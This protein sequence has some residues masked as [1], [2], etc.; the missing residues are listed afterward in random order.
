M[1][2]HPK[3]VYVQ[4]TPDDLTHTLLFSGD[5]VDP[6]KTSLCPKYIKRFNS[7]ISIFR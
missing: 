7:Y 2:T 4:N 5:T 6:T 3:H 1:S